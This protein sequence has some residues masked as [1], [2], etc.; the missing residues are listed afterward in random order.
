VNNPVIINN[1]L[2]HTWELYIIAGY[3]SQLSFN[4]YYRNIGSINT[5]PEQ[6]KNLSSSQVQDLWMCNRPMVQLDGNNN[7]KLNTDPS[8][9]LFA[10]CIC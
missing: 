1:N 5:S 10:A 6:W 9:G 8:G 3:Y 7:Y 4:Y 2:N